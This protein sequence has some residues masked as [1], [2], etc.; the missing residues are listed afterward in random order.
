[1]ET[2]CK[3]PRG[4]RSPQ[5]SH[6]FLK[7]ISFRYF[8]KNN[9]NTTKKKKLHQAG[10]TAFR[11]AF[12]FFAGWEAIFRTTH[13]IKEHHR[14]LILAPDLSQITANQTQTRCKNHHGWQAIFKI[15]KNGQGEYFKSCLEDAEYISVSLFRK[16]QQN[17]GREREKIDEIVMMELERPD[18]IKPSGWLKVLRRPEVTFIPIWVKTSKFFVPS[19]PCLDPQI[20]TSQLW[21]QT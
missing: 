9:N 14:Y 13:A 16:F 10:R 3:Q 17:R 8:P 18:P 2:C 19:T 5:I 15:S 20:W 11:N 7:G 1:M 12:F 4:N 21:K 6:Q